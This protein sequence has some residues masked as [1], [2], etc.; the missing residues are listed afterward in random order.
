MCCLRLRMSGQD[1]ADD[2]ARWDSTRSPAGVGEKPHLGRSAEEW[3]GSLFARFPDVSVFH[4]SNFP[5]QE[6]NFCSWVVSSISQ[7]FQDVRSHTWW[8]GVSPKTQ[9]GMQLRRRKE[10]SW[11]HLKRCLSLCLKTVYPFSHVVPLIPSWYMQLSN[12]SMG[13]SFSSLGTNKNVL[14]LSISGEVQV[15]L[16]IDSSWSPRRGILMLSPFSRVRLC[17]TP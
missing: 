7:A 16:A 4:W 13:I 15:Q 1:T 3:R 2:P 14:T 6:P 9:S 11:G 5:F 10:G 8:A 12:H 17:A